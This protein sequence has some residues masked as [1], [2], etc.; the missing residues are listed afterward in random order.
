MIKMAQL[1]V[2]QRSVQAVEDGT[3]DYPGISLEQ[4]RLRFMTFEGRTPMSWILGL[5]QY[6]KKLGDTMTA[7]GYIVWSE[8]DEKLS[9]KDF[10]CTLTNF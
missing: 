1:L 5:R 3:V 10:Q 8:D 7:Q 4:M 9:F 2:I 6:A